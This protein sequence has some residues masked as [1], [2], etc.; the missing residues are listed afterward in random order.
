V[1]LLLIAIKAFE[2]FETAVVHKM[3][4]Q[5]NATTVL[6]PGTTVN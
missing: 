6:D 5:T 4:Q 1:E 2:L 3:S